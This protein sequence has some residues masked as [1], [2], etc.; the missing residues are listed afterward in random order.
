MEGTLQT[1]GVRRWYEFPLTN[2]VQRW[3][4][5]SLPN[6]G[7][8][9][10]ATYADYDGSL[11]FSSAQAEDANLRPRLVINYSVPQ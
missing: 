3:L 7:V 4:A 8:L 10:R 2:A 6:N 1:N 5:G 9:L 11:L